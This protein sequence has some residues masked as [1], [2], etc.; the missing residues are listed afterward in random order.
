MSTSWKRTLWILVFAQFVSAVG[1]SSIFPFLTLYV[2]DL[3]SSTNLGTEFLAGLVF[4]VQAFTMMLTAP[5]WGALADRRGRK[6]MVERATLG[7]GVIVFLMAFARSAEDLVILR[8]VQGAVTGVFSAMTAL[9]AAS[10]PRERMGYSLG[11][12]QVGLWGGVSVGPFI[13]GISADLMGFRAAFIFTAAL[14]WVAGILVWWGVEEQFTP[15]AR[16]GDATAPG[17]FAAWQHVLSMPGVPPTYSARF[18]SRLGRTMVMPFMPLLVADLMS[19]GA[20]IATLTGVITAISAAG[21]TISAIYLGRLGD[22]VGHRQVL[23]VTALAAGLLYFPQSMTSSV[24][25]L[26]ILFSLAGA[27]AGG[28][29]PSI[30]ALL[31]GYTE[32]GE[33]GAV[34]GLESAIMAAARTISPLVAAALVSVL[35]VRSVFAAAGIILLLLALLAVRWLPAA[36]PK[37]A[38]PQPTPVPGR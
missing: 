22:R 23:I 12:L 21:G 30:S 24:W 13:G 5:F 28:I 14:L 1:F 17:F 37:P 31:A 20:N 18:L 11:T 6:V 3:G 8:A 29:M 27:A 33:E 19:E 38:P 15:Q 32:P 35:G 10:V 34:F 25:Q 16:R 9:V 36:P 7:G 26:L 4:S 2:E